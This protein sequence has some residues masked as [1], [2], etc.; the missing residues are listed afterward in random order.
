MESIALAWSAFKAFVDSWK[1]KT[2]IRFVQNVDGSYKVW[3]PFEGKLIEV[4]S[5]VTEAADITEFES[6]YKP[7]PASTWIEGKDVERSD[8]A[9]DFDVLA[10]QDSNCDIK[11][12]KDTWLWGGDCM[13]SG[14]D[15]VDSDSVKVQVVDV[16]DILGGG[17]GLVVG[18][19]I[20]KKFV[21]ANRSISV[22]APDGKPKMVPANLYL[23]V[24][25]TETHNIAKTATVNLIA[26]S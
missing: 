12:V 10:N 8:I 9:Q 2:N 23:R 6:D 5:D 19:L 22:A 25:I 3:L 7:D 17:A 18:E 1:V 11:M 13:V 26:M 21:G 4:A 16:D 15:P 14:S 20:T 24:V